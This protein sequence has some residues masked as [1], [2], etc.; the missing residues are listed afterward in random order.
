M[1]AATEEH[2]I[3]AILSAAKALESIAESLDYVVQRLEQEG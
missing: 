3:E 1:E 2:L